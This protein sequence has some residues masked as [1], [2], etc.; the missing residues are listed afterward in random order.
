MPAIE[1]DG[2]GLRRALCKLVSN[3]I[4]FT[5]AGG[6]IKVT[7]QLDGEMTRL[8]VS[9]TGVGIPPEEQA[10]VFEAF[11]RVR[12]YSG[13]GRSRHSGPRLRLPLV[14]HIFQLHRGPPGVEYAPRPGPTRNSPPP[15]PP[16]PPTPAAKTP[17]PI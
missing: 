16:R 11:T 13:S 5:P 15:A 10:R 3:A 8:A 1:G 17:P 9:D 12:P 7:A 2:R 14:K 4:K 6:S